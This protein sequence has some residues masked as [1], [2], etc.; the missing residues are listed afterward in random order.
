MLVQIATQTSIASLGYGRS[1]WSPIIKILNH[2]ILKIAKNQKFVL[3]TG[4][5]YGLNSLSQE[6]NQTHGNITTLAVLG[7]SGKFSEVLKALLNIFHAIT[8]QAKRAYIAV[9][10]YSEGKI[11]AIENY[12]SST[13]IAI[14]ASA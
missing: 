7:S 5:E 9:P 3:V 2:G 11:Q 8:G 12:L 10:T 13:L 1:L 14:I 4:Y 6:L